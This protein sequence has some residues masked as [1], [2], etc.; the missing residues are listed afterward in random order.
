MKLQ[1]HWIASEKLDEIVAAELWT[2][3]RQLRVL[4]KNGNL[5][6]MFC[7]EIISNWGR[8]KHILEQNSMNV[9]DT[10]LENYILI[11]SSGKML[12]INVAS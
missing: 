8:C 9:K 10:I 4:K 5:D 6:G 3:A 2:T 11:F 7:K 1:D 12:A